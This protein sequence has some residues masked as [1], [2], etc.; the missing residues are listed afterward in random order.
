MSYAVDLIDGCDTAAI[1]VVGKGNVQTLAAND[2]MAEA[3]GRLQEKFGV[4]PCFE[5]LD[6]S[7]Q[8]FRV[9]DLATAPRRWK[10]FTEAAADAGIAGVMALPL[11][12]PGDMLGVLNA[13]S[14]RPGE[15]T[16]ESEDLAILLTSHIAVAFAAARAEENL[17]TAVA[18]HQ[19]IGEAV[20]ILIERHR[21]SKR[22]AF[23]MLK[24]ASQDHNIKLRE[25]ARRLVETGE[26][27]EIT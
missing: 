23:A 18:S 20:G 19:E 3:G 21:V 11:R 6:S 15:L 14:R 22:E 5:V 25:I 27:S 13:Y 17:R 24:K 10:R 1:V 12:V 26:T 4:G 8:A 9:A 7:L 2:A 16:A